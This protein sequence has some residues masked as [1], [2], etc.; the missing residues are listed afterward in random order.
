MADI[1]YFANFVI[2]YKISKMYSL[3]LPSY[4]VKLSGSKIYPLIFDELR[5]K[6][7]KLTPEEWVRQ[8]FVH[9]LISYKGYP[10][11]LMANEVQLKVG[12]KLLRA[13]AVLYRR[14][15]SPRVVMEFKQPGVSITEKVV[16]QAMA[17][18]SILHVDV[19]MISNGLEH[20]AFRIKESNHVLQPMAEL[21][22]YV[23]LP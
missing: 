7:V 9:Y 3:N 20:Y 15:G 23:E 4:P 12:S 14:D 10:A 8:H 19:I 2:T 16:R 11:A 13:D 21:P 1:V 5:L 22:N 17:Y 6:W 18:N